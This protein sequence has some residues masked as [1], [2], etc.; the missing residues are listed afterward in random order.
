MTMRTALGRAVAK[1]ALLLGAF[2]FG[3]GILCAAKAVA[4]PGD[5][6]AAPGYLLFGDSLLERVTAAVGKDKALKIVVLG[7]TSS[8][9]PGPGGASFAY[10]ARLEAALSRRM[11]GIKV[12]VETE[13]KPR[14]SA[15]DMS[16]SIEKILLDQKPSLVVWQTGTFE[17]TRGTDPEEFRAT[18]SDGVEKLQTGGADVVLMN[19]QYS[20]RTETIVALGAYAEGIRWVA[21]EREVPVYDRLAIMRHWYDAGQFNLYAATKD[22]KTAKSVHD[23]IGRTLASSI[24]DAARLEAQGATPQ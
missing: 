16:E 15:E 8:S 23:C 11:P 3:A 18:V 24:I 21:R 10:P 4:E 6:C 13:I 5:P 22:M 20:P 7:G 1:V 12:T 19:M 17:A 2:V 14:Q 9:L